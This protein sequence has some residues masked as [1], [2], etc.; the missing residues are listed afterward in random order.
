MSI[1]AA[2][3]L[4]TRERHPVLDDPLKWATP[5]IWEPP[6]FNARKFQKRI[7]RIV[8]TA[9]GQPIVRLVWAW[10]KRCRDFRFTKWDSFGRGL[11]G[12]FSYRYRAATVP[13]NDVDTVDI[14][15]PRWILEQRYEPGQYAAEWERS[16]WAS[17]CVG[18]DGSGNPIE[19]RCE[20]KGPPPFE[21]Y[22]FLMAVSEH[23]PGRTCCA[24]RWRD[25]RVNCWGY[26]RE[27]SQSDLDL[28][29][30]A[31]ARRNA[32][33]YKY[34]PHEPL[35]AEA[36][37]EIQRAAFIEEDIIEQDKKVQIHDLW[38][39]WVGTHGWRINEP[40]HAKSLTHGRYH[41]MPQRR[42]SVTP[43]GLLIPSE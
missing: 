35:P 2:D 33:P 23:D 20:L 14:C 12:E 22:G 25:Y 17:R 32:D 42:F 5:G 7:D 27:P 28:L 30:E 24:R 3:H 21:W 4:S 11:E 1:A 43:S 10:D 31:V 38:S 29:A 37:D 34:S 26:Y 36:L 41:F 8:G 15:P 40:R 13:L 19:Q 18:K 16:R 9:D 39:D 6:A